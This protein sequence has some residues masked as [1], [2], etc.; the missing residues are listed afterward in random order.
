M[1]F[2]RRIFSEAPQ[3][4]NK[5]GYLIAEIGYGQRRAIKGIIEKASGFELIDVKED[6]YLID[7]VIVVKWIN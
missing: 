2:Y 3:Y 5:C 7:R 4:L 1:D 6:Q